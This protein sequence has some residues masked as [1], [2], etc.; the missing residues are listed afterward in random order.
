MVADNLV[1]VVLLILSFCVVADSMV[2]VWLLVPG[3]D[4]VA[5]S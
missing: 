2:Q 4:M 3:S 1:H 5:A